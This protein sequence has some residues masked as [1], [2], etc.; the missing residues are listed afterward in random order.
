M[1]AWGAPSLTRVK[2]AAS[3]LDDPKPMPTKAARIDFRMR[4]S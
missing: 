4:F 1:A 2:P 3:R